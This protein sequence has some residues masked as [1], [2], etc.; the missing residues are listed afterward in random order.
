MLS[1]RRQRLVAFSATALSPLTEPCLPGTRLTPCPRYAA[2]AEALMQEEVQDGG[3]AVQVPREAHAQGVAAPLLASLPLHSQASPNNGRHS[4]AA[5]RQRT[6]RSSP[7][8]LTTGR[9]AG[10]Q[11]MRSQHPGRARAAD[12]TAIQATARTRAVVAASSGRCGA[13]SQASG[14]T[15]ASPLAPHLRAARLQPA[16]VAVARLAWCPPCSGA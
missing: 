4:S 11:L 16:A 14:Q 12:A 5:Q 8:A 3:A 13:C 9:A 2:V 1:L 6:A 7:L 15:V 10:Q